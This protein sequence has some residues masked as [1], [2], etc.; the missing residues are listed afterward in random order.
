M[1]SRS[2]WKEKSILFLLPGLSGTI[3]FFLLPVCYCLVY[4]LSGA[5]GRFR[6]VGLENYRALFQSEAFGLAFKNTYLWMFL[7]LAVILLISLVMIYY[8]DCSR[9]ILGTLL[10]FC[11]PMLLPPTVIVRCIGGRDIS[12]VLV[13]LCVF[14]WKYL[15]FH[16]LL[17]KSM[18]LQMQPEWV[19]AAVLE[20]A[21][22]WKV[23]RHIRL[24]FLWPY[25][26]FLIVFDGICFFRL[27]RECYLLYGKYPPDEVYLVS[28]FFFNNFQNLN[29]QRLSAAVMAVLIPVLVLNGILLKVGKKYEMV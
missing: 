5:S 24:P 28:H 11:L 1:S 19:E 12:P 9:K 25:I 27:F 15:G 8:L 21:G 2:K 17:L 29:F 13:L 18:E 14:L 10:L 4:A 7:Y 26:R 23:F 6:Y 16:V 22:K 3:I 20:H